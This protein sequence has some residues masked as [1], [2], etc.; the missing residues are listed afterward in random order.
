[1][2]FYD[3]LLLILL[4]AIWGSSFIFMRLLA[5]ALGPIATADLRILIAGTALA[6]FLKFQ[7]RS[8]EWKAHWKQYLII[9][10]LNSG[11]PFLLFSFAA[12]HLPA[13]VSVIINAMTPLFGA[14]SAVIWLG[15][16]MSVR[17]VAGLFLGITGVAIIRGGGSFELTPMTTLAMGA[18]ML[19]T[20]FYAVGGVYV[21]LKAHDIGPTAIA[22]GS[23]L[24]VGLLFLPLVFFSPV[25]AVLTVEIIIYTMIFA[26]FCSAI[27]YLIYYRLLKIL[28]P[29]KATTVTFLIPVFGFIWGALFL[30]EEITFAMV[31]GGIIVLSA[32]Y[33]V[34]GK[35]KS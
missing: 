7:N 15:E 13:S 12:L 16:K 25:P 4:S 10:L 27:A 6:I 22:T 23:Q 32:I 1:M 28:G 3:Y 20:M 2:F 17:I 5:P 11:F 21:K 24:L 9:G 14:I 18:C 35:K 30:N 19:A 29:T 34:T 31:V 8:L 33:F 26:L